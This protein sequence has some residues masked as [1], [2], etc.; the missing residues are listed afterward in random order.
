MTDSRVRSFGELSGDTNPIHLDREAARRSGFRDRVAH[1]ALLLA[2]VSRVIGRELPGDFSLWLS[3]EVDFRAP[4]YIGDE[5]DIEARVEHVSPAFGIIA[6]RIQ[7]YRVKD[8]VEVLRVEAKVKTLDQQMA[9][10]YTPLAEQRVLITGASRGLGRMLTTRLLAAGARVVGVYRSSEPDVGELLP[11]DGKDA[12][13]RLEL[14]KCDVSDSTQLEKLFATLTHDPLHSFVHAASPRVEEVPLERL[15]WDVVRPHLETAVKGG[16]EVVRRC[17]PHFEKTGTGRVILIGSEA[18][19]DPRPNWVHYVTAKSALLGMA[20][21]LAVEL[22]PLGATVNVVSPGAVF[23]SDMF[24]NT[25]KTVIRNQ[26]P[27]KRLVTEEEVAEVVCFLL[28]AGGSFI[29]G[30]NVPMT[31]GRVFLS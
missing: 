31:G 22:A 23:T 7:A 30:S 28:E 3:S 2:E 11:P 8:R 20:R 12:R 19:H 18:V 14:H 27:L 24:P 16:L 5:L 4:V 13:H 29:T 6:L 21:S 26:T 10:S 1:G 25:V 17:L 15:E 9:I